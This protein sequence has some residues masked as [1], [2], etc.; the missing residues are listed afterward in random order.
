VAELFTAENCHTGPACRVS[1]LLT[2]RI[3]KM[4]S[5]MDGF[6]SHFGFFLPCSDWAKSAGI[7]FF[8]S[9]PKKDAERV[10]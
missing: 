1:L 8:S 5:A 4:M 9:Y 6:D 3:R 7:N 10:S 2:A